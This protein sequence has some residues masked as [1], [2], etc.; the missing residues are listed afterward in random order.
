MQN[1][2]AVF[3]FAQKTPE[4]VFFGASVFFEKKIYD[5]SFKKHARP[6]DFFKG[7]F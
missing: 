5:F 6:I 3:R 1:L 7:V 2:R 4:E